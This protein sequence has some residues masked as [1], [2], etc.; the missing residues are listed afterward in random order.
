[1]MTDVRRPEAILFDVDG[2][3]YHQP[4]VRREMTRQLARFCFRSPF[5]G[6]R[7]VR[8][9]SAYRRAQENLRL[10]ETEDAPG[11]Q[12]SVACSGTRLDTE[13]ATRIV[14]EWM[15]KRPLQVVA[16]FRREGLLELLTAAQKAGIRRGVFSDYPAGGKLRALGCEGLFDSILSAQDPAVRAFKPSPR[17]LVESLRRMGVAPGEALHVGDRPE[18]D[19]EAARRAGIKCVIIG[20]PETRYGPGWSG[21]PSFPRLQEVLGI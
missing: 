1:M 6:L 12:L 9:L 8:F 19:G 7:T 20:L 13:L 16:A 21:I 14:E 18:V 5:A 15:G 17:G 3:L 11:R 10:E 4:P 2:T